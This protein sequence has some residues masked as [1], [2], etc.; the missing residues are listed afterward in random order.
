M[1]VHKTDF[2]SVCLSFWDIISHTGPYVT[3]NNQKLS[4]CKSSIS[5]LRRKKSSKNKIGKP[6]EPT[7]KPLFSTHL[8]NILKT[9]NYLGPS[10][11]LSRNVEICISGRLEQLNC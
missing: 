3:K 1:P 6:Q 4:A 2:G 11:F 8:M 5:V 10:P 7:K 9:P